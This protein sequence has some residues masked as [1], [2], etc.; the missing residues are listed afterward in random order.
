MGRAASRIAAASIAAALW[1]AAATARAQDEGVLSPAYLAVLKRYASGERAAALAELAAW[2]EDRLRH[3]MTQLGA[4]RRAARSCN[5]CGAQSR[6]QGLP[7]RA[8]LMLHAD[9]AL[10]DWRAGRSARLADS[11][12]AEYV[13][14]MADDPTHAAFVRRLLEATVAVHH[15][16]MRWGAALDWGDRTL[17]IAPGSVP[18]LLA[19][20]AI[21]ETA[22][23]LVAPVE[24][25]GLSGDPA[26]RGLMARVE[27]GREAA[28]HYR[29]ARDLARRARAADDANVETGLRLGR[30]AWRLGEREEAKA[31]LEAV[32][33]AG[34]PLPLVFLARL[35]AGGVLE[36]EGRLDEAVAAYEAAIALRPRD[37]AAA[38]ALSEARHRR[39][40]LS[41]AR[42]ALLAGLSAGRRRAENDPYWDYP[43]SVSIDALAR[44]EALRRELSP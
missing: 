6:W 15:V 16:E 26:T 39:G 28:D 34:Q 30:L 35:F 11:A 29:R 33:R 22:G 44:L 37:Q 25:R 23:T 17:K 42:A 38:V 19:M 14:M 4:L 24:R 31:E 13:G 8:G 36:D 41:G 2:P 21:E 3:E 32:A 5:G 10:G 12:L 18:V 43:Y 20:A 27:A 7:L 40:D 9:A 1:L